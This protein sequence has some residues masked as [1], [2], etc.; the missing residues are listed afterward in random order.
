MNPAPPAP[1]RRK[2]VYLGLATN[3]RV[4][5]IPRMMMAVLKLLAPTRP[6]IGRMETMTPRRAFMLPIFL[7]LLVT[8]QA[9]KRITAT[10]AN[11]E[12]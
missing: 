1:I 3:T 4:T 5:P 6:A 8:S 9:R 11:S 10:L 2:G 7:P 12:G